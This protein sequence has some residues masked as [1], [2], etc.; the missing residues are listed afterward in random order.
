MIGA[1]L[2]CRGVGK[3]G[4]STFLQEFIREQSL[5]FIGL[6][7]T[8]KKDYSQALFRRIDP[9]NQFCW[10]WSASI[11]RSGGILG[12]FRFSRF[13][14]C[15]AVTSRFF[16]KVTLMDLKIQQ[17]WCLVIVYGAAQD[18]EKDDFL[19]DLGDICSDQSLPL[20]I[21]G[22][23]N[24]LRG[25][26]EKNKALKPS[27]WND[28]FNYIINTCEMREIDMSGGQFTWSNNQ[29]VPTLEKLDRFLVSWEWEL[30]FPLT[31]VHKLSREISDHNPII[32]DTMEGREKQSKEFRFDKRW[33]KD[34]SFLPKV[35][36]VWAQPVRAI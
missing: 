2:N 14:V 30:L 12:G 23:F 5:D 3:K 15:S 13:T 34:E 10:K 31:T 26:N 6:H 19:T 7:E 27:R 16:I 17:K 11:G 4:M 28:M 21:G 18:D 9:L 20:L 35:V 29:T 25:A 32:L 1:S 33:L 24:L 8:I 22:D 36:R